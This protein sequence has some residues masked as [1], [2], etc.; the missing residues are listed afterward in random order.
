MA[1]TTKLQ[2]L[3]TGFGLLSD[4]TRLAALK[5]LSASPR[6]V[7]AMCSA[8]GLKQPLLSYHLGLLRVGRLVEG[9]RQ[10]KSVMYQ[11]HA[12]GLKELADAVADL[13]PRR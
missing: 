7:C 10:G 9:V 4:P 13:V 8:L 5:M 6:N 1:K 3:A 11:L 12:A 2:N